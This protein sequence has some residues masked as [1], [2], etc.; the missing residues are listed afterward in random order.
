MSYEL[1]IKKDLVR[2][3]SVGVDEHQLN[4]RPQPLEVPMC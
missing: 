3:T 1:R 4:P 2:I